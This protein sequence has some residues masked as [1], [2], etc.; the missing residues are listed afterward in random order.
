MLQLIPSGTKTSQC[1]LINFLD[2]LWCGENDFIWCFFLFA[3]DQVWST[4]VSWSWCDWRHFSNGWWVGC[5]THFVSGRQTIGRPRERPR[6][7][8]RGLF[9]PFL[10]GRTSVSSIR[11][12]ADRTPDGV[13]SALREHH[14]PLLQ[15]W[16]YYLVHPDLC[17]RQHIIISQGWWLP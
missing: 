14:S 9:T 11:S 16:P 10:G 3:L 4:G 8:R 15:L 2:I 13:K 5:R 17:T 6:S 7:I 1:L 12:E